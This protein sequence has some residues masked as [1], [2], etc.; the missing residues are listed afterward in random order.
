[1]ENRIARLFTIDEANKT[2]P[3][4]KNIVRD[5]ISYSTQL[6]YLTENFEETE[7]NTTI[8]SL[9]IKI[10]EFINELNEIGCQYKGFIDSYGLVDFPSMMN[11]EPILLCWKS[12]ETEIMFYHSEQDG[13]SGRIPIPDD[14]KF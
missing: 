11:D 9:I 12:D 1:M 2:L 4:V 5:I 8:E 6:S 3:L 13:F 7:N 14:K 10:K